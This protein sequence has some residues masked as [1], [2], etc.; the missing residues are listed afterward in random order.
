M[1]PQWTLVLLAG[2]HPGR[3]TTRHGYRPGIPR[4]RNQEAHQESD[5]ENEDGE[6]GRHDSTLHDRLEVLPKRKHQN[7]DAAEEAKDKEPG[8]QRYASLCHPFED[9]RHCDSSMGIAPTID[10]N[11]W[12]IKVG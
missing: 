12:A 1:R 3:L 6:D 11:R 8:Q 9:V 10:L 5:C 4:N 2:P 7:G